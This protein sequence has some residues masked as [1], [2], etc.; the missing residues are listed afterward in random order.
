MLYAHSS[1]AVQ[2]LPGFEVRMSWAMN[3]EIVELAGECG[4]IAKDP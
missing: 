2:S 3:D 1:F 4:K